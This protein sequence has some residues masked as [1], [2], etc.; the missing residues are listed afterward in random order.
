MYGNI[1]LAVDGSEQNKDAVRQAVSLAEKLGSKITAVYVM[2]NT[3]LK[4][5]MFGGD[6][7]A[8][9]RQAI[10]EKSAKEAFDFA[11]AMAASKGIGFETKLLFGKPCES[12]AAVSGDYD[13]LVCGTLGRSGLAKLMGSVS[14]SLVQYAKCPVLVI[15]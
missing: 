15:R 8:E 3:D 11:E 4:P 10:T 14:K 12:I 1:L 2:P 7:G 9:E 13:L 5:N 6:V